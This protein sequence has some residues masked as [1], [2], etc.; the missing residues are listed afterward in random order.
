MKGIIPKN[1][2]KI[3]VNFPHLESEQRDIPIIYIRYWDDTVIYVGESVN[4]YS[5]RHL[6]YRC[7][8]YP[9]SKDK[10]NFVRILN[11]PL[12][13]RKRRKWEAKLVCWLNPVLQKMN[14][15]INK[16]NLDYKLKSNLK[17]VKR[18]NDIKAERRI[19][20]NLEEFLKAVE[21]YKERKIK[22]PNVSSDSLL[23]NF[24]KIKKRK[25]C[26]HN[27]E[28]VPAFGP[29]GKFFPVSKKTL[30]L[31]DKAYVFA[32]TRMRRIFKEWKD[33]E[34]DR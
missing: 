15:Y 24:D 31:I 11:A 20:T 32:D 28:E 7:R 21:K 4:F 19:I 2:R 1:K 13:T 26:Y 23:H 25:K 16:A 22:D 34:H 5:G 33:D 27:F 14:M 29:D 8:D 10:T 6:R 9:D 3:K 12:D 30:D 18:L 17:I